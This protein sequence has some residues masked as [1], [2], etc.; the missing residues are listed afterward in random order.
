MN[1]NLCRNEY[2]ELLNTIAGGLAH[3]PEFIKA[4]IQYRGYSMI[5]EEIAKKTKNAING[6]VNEDYNF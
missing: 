6:I 5:G 4:T 1:I 2:V 3:N